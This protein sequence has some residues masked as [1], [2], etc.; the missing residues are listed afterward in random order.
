MWRKVKSQYD[1]SDYGNSELIC[2][3]IIPF[4]DI[5]ITLIPME[6]NKN[7]TL[8]NSSNILHI[9]RQTING[10][11]TINDSNNVTLLGPDVVPDLSNFWNKLKFC[12]NILFKY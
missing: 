11:I 9:G 10:P 4:K 6:G 2:K 12:Y 1:S 7:I 8:N 5:E 3:Y